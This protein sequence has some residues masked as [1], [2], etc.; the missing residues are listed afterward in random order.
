MKSFPHFKEK[1]VKDMKGRNKTTSII[2][3]MTPY[4]EGIYKDA[5]RINKYV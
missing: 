2:E 1:Q 3:D 4:I 5:F